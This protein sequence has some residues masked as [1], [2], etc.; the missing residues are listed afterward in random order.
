MTK[1]EGGFQVEV[2]IYI[3]LKGVGW[4]PSGPLPYARPE[5]L[6]LISLKVWFLK[7][8]PLAATQRGLS[9]SSMLYFKFKEFSNNVDTE[10]EYK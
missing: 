2:G 5:I 10:N 7:G 4:I 9:F 8:L 1:G 6:K 3:G